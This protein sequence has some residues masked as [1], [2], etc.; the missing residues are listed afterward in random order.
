M[1]VYL[2]H[3][4]RPISPLHT[5][6]HY[7]GFAHDLYQRLQQHRAGTGA[8]LCAVAKERR[9]PY[10]RG[11]DVVAV[12]QGDRTLERQLK[13]RKNAPCLCYKCNPKLL[14]FTLADVPELAF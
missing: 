4:D 7:L 11:F 10:G 5:C 14:A 2:L 12:W 8:R 9:V 13:N 1:Y 3:F 6:Q